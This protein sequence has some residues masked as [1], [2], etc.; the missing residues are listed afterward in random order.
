MKLVIDKKLANNNY[1]VSISLADILEA[2][3]DMFADFGKI[4]I[5]IGGELKVTGGVTADATVG[6]SFKYLPAD[7]PIVRVF[8][9]AQYSDKAETVAKAFA[10]TVTERIE[11]AVTA[12]KLKQDSFTGI[13]E[14]QL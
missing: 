5:N 3:T 2:E 4:Q 6:D 7:F 1:E 12:L 9:K 14:V 13:T 8:T 10:D 11:T